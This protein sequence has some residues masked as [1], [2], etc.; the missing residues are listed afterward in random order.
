MVASVA[1]PR[2]LLVT[3]TRGSGK[4]SYLIDHVRG[5]LRD[6][7]PARRILVVTFSPRGAAR[8]AA[9]LPGQVDGAPSDGVWLQTAQRLCAWLLHHCSRAMGTISPAILSASERT[10]LLHEAAARTAT[11]LGSDHP[12]T[13]ALAGGP[14]LAEIDLL[15]GAIAGQGGSP[16]NLQQIVDG[17]PGTAWRGDR[18]VLDGIARVYR[19]FADLC[20]RAGVMTYQ[21]VAPLVATVL[22]DTAI[23][24]PLASR[25]DHM[26]VDDLDRA[27]PAQLEVLARLGSRARLIATVDPG[28]P[29][30]P[31]P[32]PVRGRGGAGDPHPIRIRLRNG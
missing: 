29:H 30:P 18:A 14:G 28:N 16:A 8:F 5:L 15:L 25:I 3:G 24:G 1:T 27:E 13:P 6:G 9:R 10:M 2:A 31:T 17:L 23:A 21:D 12:L 19:T 7:A 4:T 22:S 26:V 11:T 20:E 32:S